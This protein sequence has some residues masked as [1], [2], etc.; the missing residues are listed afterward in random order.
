M[1]AYWLTFTDGS[2]AC[3][4]GESD[5]DAKRIAENI[6][7]KKVAGGEYK[8]ISAVKLPYPALPVIWQFEHPINGKTPTFCHEPE[9]CKGRGACPQ[10]YSCTE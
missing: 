4:E 9:K 3:C 5:F 7:G 6:T 10:S 1:T 2:K 8:N